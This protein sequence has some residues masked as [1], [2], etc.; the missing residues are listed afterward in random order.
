MSRPMIT[1]VHARQRG[2]TI[3]EIM[4]AMVLSLILMAGVIEVFMG[5]KN[6]YRVNEALGRLQE[7]GR[8]ALEFMSRDVRMA[9]YS[10]CSRY[11]P[12]TNTL[13]DATN[14]AYNFAVGASGYNNVGATPPAELTAINV[15]PKP[16]TDVIIV[17]RQSD[18]PVRIVK[19]N[20]AANMF[21]ENLGE[22]EGACAD[23]S[24]RFSGIC[25]GDILMVSDCRKSRVFQATTVGETG[26]G[27]TSIKV[28]HDNR[29]TVTP[30]NADSSWGGNSAPEDEQFNDDS[31]LVKV[32]T[33]VYYVA[34][35]ADGVPSLYRK[36][37]M[38]TALELAQGVENLQVL[39]GVDTSPTDVN[40]S[41]DTY[42]TAAAVTNWD[43]VVSVRLNLLMR[44]ID[45]NLAEA[46]QSY[47]YVGADHDADDRRIRKEFTALVTLRNRVR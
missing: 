10:G 8:M 7:E 31:E 6:T 34:D 45:N 13:A 47:R 44:T 9:G 32:S 43:N 21:T 25:P 1:A 17:R 40:Q 35:N 19:N 20:D 15:A 36:D 11:G 42:V 3:V 12:V 33:Y 37:G 22:D 16:D 39:Y 4:V 24:N 14:I 27:E 29:N 46:M 38:A 5:S 2:L 23:G 41:A 28:N 26:G 30:G 18:N